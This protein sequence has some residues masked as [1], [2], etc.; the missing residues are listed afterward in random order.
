LEQLA[1]LFPTGINKIILSVQSVRFKFVF[2]T[3]C[4]VIRE[5]ARM[6]CLIKI[7]VGGH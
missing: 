4:A 1:A 7:T 2:Y 6:G 3:A 5:S